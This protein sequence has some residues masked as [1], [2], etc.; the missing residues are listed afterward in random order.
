ML[1]TSVSFF[2]EVSTET[3]NYPH[4]WFHFLMSLKSENHAQSWFHFLMS[5]KSENHAQ[6]WFHFLMSLK[7]KNH[8]QRWFHFLMSLKSENHAQCSLLDHGF[9]EENALEGHHVKG[10]NS[11]MDSNRSS[12]D[13][14]NTLW[15][16]HMARAAP[17]VRRLGSKIPIEEITMS[18]TGS[19]S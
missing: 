19:K 5:L 17:G 16:E 14:R 2:N 4:S 1:V 6:S 12:L 18:T 15:K 9:Q 8:A 3:Q 13:E 11:V 10:Q 7:S